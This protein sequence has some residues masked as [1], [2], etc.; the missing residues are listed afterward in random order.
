MEIDGKSYGTSSVTKGL[1][2]HRHAQSKQQ[3]QGAGAEEKPAAEGKSMHDHQGQEGPH[4][5]IQK[6]Q[7]EHG[8]ADKAEVS[9]DGS[10]HTVTTTHGSHV[11]ESKGHPSV[12]HVSAHLGHASGTGGAE[13]SGE[14]AAGEGGSSL[15]A[16]GIGSGDSEG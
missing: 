6:V 15:E 9:H 7:Q 3:P 10:S 8:P 2:R 11:H 4:E 16:M 14:S 12:G 5:E 13:P 1:A